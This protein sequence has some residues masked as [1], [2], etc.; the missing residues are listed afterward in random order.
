MALI[1]LNE[2]DLNRIVESTIKRLLETDCGGVMGG[3]GGIPA[4]DNDG[5]NSTM[6]TGDYQFLKPCGLVRRKDPS[7][8][9]DKPISVNRKKKTKKSDE[10]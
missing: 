8:R 7:L 9:R 5:A 10:F 1:K 3:G 6:S 2:R 4:A